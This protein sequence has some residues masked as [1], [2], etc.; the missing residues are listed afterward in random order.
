MLEHLIGE[1]TSELEAEKIELLATRETLHYQA[2]HDALTGL[3]NRSAILDILRRELTHARVEGTALGVVLTDIDHFKK[4]NDTL[5]HLAG[6]AILREAAQRMLNSIRQSDFIGRYGGE[7]FLI[8]LPGLIPG[9]YS[10]RLHRLQTAIGGEHFR[11]H[12]DFV[13]ITSSFGVT[14]AYPDGEPVSVE[15]LIHRTD[16]ALY[17]AKAQGRDRIFFHGRPTPPSGSPRVS[18]QES[19]DSPSIP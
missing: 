14:W 7:E 13:R 6:D 3:W 5:G 4:I 2:T 9:G 15:E 16:E 8:I 18:V 17:I 19:Y 11:H 1:R 12:D 10:T